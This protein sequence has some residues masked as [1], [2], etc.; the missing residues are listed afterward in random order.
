ML[1]SSVV[2]TPIVQCLEVN[3]ETAGAVRS[4]Q[5]SADPAVRSP[6]LAVVSMAGISFSLVL[7]QESAA[8]RPVR[9]AA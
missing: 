7:Q 1:S 4:T 3:R 5:S 6:L 2:A 8:P 9:S